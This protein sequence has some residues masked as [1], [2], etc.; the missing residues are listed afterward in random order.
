MQLT[1][2][3]GLSSVGG[4][5]V[6]RKHTGNK[7]GKNT[8]QHLL[9]EALF[10]FFINVNTSTSREKTYTGSV[11]LPTSNEAKS[12]LTG[13]PG[14]RSMECLSKACSTVPPLPRSLRERK[15]E[16]LQPQWDVWE[17]LYSQHVFHIYLTEHFHCDPFLLFILWMILL[18]KARSTPLAISRWCCKKVSVYQTTINLS[19]SDSPTDPSGGYYTS[20][21]ASGL[22]QVLCPKHL[23]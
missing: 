3:L 7:P 11:R 5:D 13:F 4:T 2:W 18:I 9:K 15:A 19:G 23:T 16:H 1:D 12:A 22:P 21:L 17:T 6:L 10:L 8:R 20:W 14:S